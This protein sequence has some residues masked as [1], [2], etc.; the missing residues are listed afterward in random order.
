MSSKNLWRESIG[1]SMPVEKMFVEADLV[2]MDHGEEPIRVLTQ[3][4]LVVNK[5]L[6]HLPERQNPGLH[7]NTLTELDPLGWRS[8]S[9]KLEIGWDG[10]VCEVE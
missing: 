9:V 2:V 1:L 8:P 3:N 6:Y 10:H 5:L 4:L 7:P